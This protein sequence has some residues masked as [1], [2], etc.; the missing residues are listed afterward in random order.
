MNQINDYKDI[1]KWRKFTKKER[2]RIADEMEILRD[3]L[4]EFREQKIPE[5][6]EEEELQ[7]LAMGVDRAAEEIEVIVHDHRLKVIQDRY[8]R[9]NLN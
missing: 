5:T 3:Q 2:E 4:R 6:A 9:E 7:I 1:A 8:D